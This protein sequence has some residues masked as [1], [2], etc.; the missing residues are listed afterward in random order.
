MYTETR[1]HAQVL[2]EVETCT[3]V[4]SPGDFVEVQVVKEKI[5]VAITMTV[6]TVMKLAR[7]NN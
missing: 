1:S 6:A 5:R 2:G 4:F 7:K 3:H